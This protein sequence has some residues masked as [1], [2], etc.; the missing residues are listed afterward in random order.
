MCVFEY[1]NITAK[2]NVGRGSLLSPLPTGLNWRA[3]FSPIPRLY[4]RF[5]ILTDKNEIS[6][7]DEKKIM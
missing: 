1:L 7:L 6:K 5:L 3:N 2:S 4:I